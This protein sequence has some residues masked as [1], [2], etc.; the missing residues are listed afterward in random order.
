MQ[1]RA[2]E[3]LSDDEALALAAIHDEVTEYRHIRNADLFTL[4]KATPLLERW[5]R[6]QRNFAKDV[7]NRPIRLPEANVANIAP[8]KSTG[9]LYE[10]LRQLGSAKEASQNATG[11]GKEKQPLITEMMP[12]LRTAFPETFRTKRMQ[13]RA[14]AQTTD[15]GRGG[16]QA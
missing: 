14:R 7:L 1:E 2:L 10:R 11:V 9:T 16:A 15:T 4:T 5:E 3:D 8:L 12:K 13:D 6:R